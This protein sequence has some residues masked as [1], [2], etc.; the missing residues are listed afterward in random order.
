MASSEYLGLGM[1]IT[2]FLTE[3]L[4]NKLAVW[5]EKLGVIWLLS[6]FLRSAAREGIT[7]LQMKCLLDRWTVPETPLPTK[8]LWCQDLRAVSYNFYNFPK[9]TI[10]Q[11]CRLYAAI[12]RSL[13][14]SAGFELFEESVQKRLL[15]SLTVLI[16]LS[17]I[18]ASISLHFWVSVSFFFTTF[19]FFN[20]QVFSRPHEL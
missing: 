10:W 18:V 17:T 7:I 6:S 4:C 15:L 11:S 13:C 9:P 14:A 16:L 20:V 2:E 12:G 1:E 8:P 19:Q 3:N 5:G